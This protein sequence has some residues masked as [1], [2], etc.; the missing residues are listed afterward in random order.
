M[1][2]VSSGPGQVA[3]ISEIILI[4]LQ[5]LTSKCMLAAYRTLLSAESQISRQVLKRVSLP[6]YIIHVQGFGIRQ[7]M[8]KTS[9]IICCAAISASMKQ[10]VGR[11]GHKALRCRGTFCTLRTQGDG[12]SRCDENGNIQKKKASSAVR[13][14]SG[15]RFV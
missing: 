14:C 2:L 7:P 5:A 13:T 1:R 15:N 12:E 6:R 3:F 9:R 4:D 11:S 10:V 8:H